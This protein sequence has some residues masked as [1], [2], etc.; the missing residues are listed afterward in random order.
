MSVNHEFVWGECRV[1]Y[2]TT[3]DIAPGETV[4]CRLIVKNRIP[5][6]KHIELKWHLPEGWTVS[7]VR[8]DYVLGSATRYTPDTVEIPF[9]IT[10]GEKT[11]VTNRVICEITSATRPTAALIPVVFIG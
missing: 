3:P 6:P 4:K 5:A 8:H 11:E 2:D 7:G 10:A 9:E 1:V